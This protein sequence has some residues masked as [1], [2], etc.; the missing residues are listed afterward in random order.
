MPFII[1]ILL[2]LFPLSLFAQPT[3]P[4]TYSV[5]TLNNGTYALSSISGKKTLVLFVHAQQTDEAWLKSFTS[6]QSS[7]NIL[8]IPVVDI[9]NAESSGSPISTTR[10]QQLGIRFPVA[11][12]VNLAQ[13]KNQSGIYKWLTDKNL[14]QRFDETPQSLPSIYV[15]N[16]KGG[17]YA[18]VHQ[19]LAAGSTEIQQILSVKF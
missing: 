5:E 11:N 4:Y 10:L 9:A 16:E 14:N 8:V 17:L 3:S 19:K 6:L 15:I 18:V 7:A 13:A 12:P 2:S 1:L